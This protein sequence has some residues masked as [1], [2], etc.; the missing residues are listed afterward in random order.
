MKTFFQFLSF[1]IGIIFFSTFSF[2]INKPKELSPEIL[3]NGRNLFLQNQNDNE[4]TLSATINADK[5][6]VCI[7]GTS[8][9]I[10]FTAANGTAPYIFTYK[11][12]NGASQTISTTASSNSVTLNVPTNAAGI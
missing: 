6:G 10:T 2:S 11:I 9:I 8:P 4:N 5:L 12:N 3:L 7:N 1:L